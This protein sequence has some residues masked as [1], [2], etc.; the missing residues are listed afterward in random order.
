MKIRISVI[1]LITV[2]AMT[3]AA[4][5]S[6]CGKGRN[7]KGNRVNNPD[8]Y[9]ADFTYFSG[10]DSLVRDMQE[11]DSFTVNAD[12]T[13][14]KVA[15]SI[16][17]S[18]EDTGYKMSNIENINDYVYTAETSG[19]YTIKIKAKRAAGTIEIKSNFT[20]PEQITEEDIISSGAGISCYDL[21]TG[22][23][24]HAIQ[25]YIMPF[26][27]NNYD[28]AYKA[29][30]SFAE[31]LG[32]EEVISTLVPNGTVGIPLSGTTVYQFDRYYNDVPVYGSMAALTVYN[33]DRNKIYLIVSYNFASELDL[34]TTPE[35]AEN[36]LSELI[37]ERY[38]CE[39]MTD[40]E[41]V[42]YEGSLAWRILLENEVPEMVMLDAN[43][44]SELYAE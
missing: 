13:K 22:T 28:D 3:L 19:E 11:G 21:D 10:E 15:I 27:V 32:G 26:E 33:D 34:D 9:S 38:G 42:I 29:V 18:G 7:F 20:L 31:L 24:L 41:L 43:S 1:I 25:D 12:I 37:K 4:I 6:S 35:I 2:T 40:P 39:M 23:Q 8:Y 30:A 36:E 17:L 14:G 44:G 16:A 5:I